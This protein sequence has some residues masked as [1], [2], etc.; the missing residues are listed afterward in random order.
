VLPIGTVFHQLRKTARTRM[1]ERGIDPATSAAILGH[2]VNVSLEVY[3]QVTPRMLQKAA[4]LMD[5]DGDQDNTPEE[6]NQA[7][8]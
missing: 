3:T 7:K 5:D 2:G 8:H 4:D 1:A 6:P